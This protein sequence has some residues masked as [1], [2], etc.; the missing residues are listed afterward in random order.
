MEEVWKDVVGFE[1]L[2]QVSNLGRIKSFRRAKER[3]L[4]PTTQRVGNK[5]KY[6]RQIVTL[7]HKSYK[8][9]RLVAEA[10]IPNPYNLPQINHKDF[11]TSNN[12]VY[13]LEWC[14]AKENVQ[15]NIIHKRNKKY[16]YIDKTT[17][18]NLYKQ[19][20]TAKEI[21]KKFNVAKYIITTIVDKNKIRRKDYKR[22][23]KYISIEK[24]KE[25][26]H[27]GLKNREISKQY[28][29]PQNYIARRKYQINKGEI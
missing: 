13:N 14:S 26:F 15:W 25:L 10:F 8:V 16:H 11:D 3:I 21:S 23:S 1:G 12:C 5:C 27:L 6:T 18:I 7:N 20:I 22:K 19:G 17:V 28:N 9:H 29:I 4:K 24:L 2:Y